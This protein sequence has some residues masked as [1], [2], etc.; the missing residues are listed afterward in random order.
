MKHY[1]ASIDDVFKE[2]QS[3]REGLTSEQAES[4][5]LK[6]GKN[7]LAEPEKDSIIKQFF[8][9]M[10]DPMIIMLLAAAVI[11]AGVSF[12]SG[13]GEI[14]DVI[15]I[16]FVVVVNA[17]LG[18]Y[19]ENKAEK[20]IEALAEIAAATTTVLR[21]GKPVTIKNEDLVVGD[22]VLLESG[23]AIPADGRIIGNTSMKIEEAV[24][25]WIRQCLKKRNRV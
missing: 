10:A 25:T 22:V 11:S 3:S 1:C 13:D 24:E 14:A 7:K 12:Y 20:A 23:D 16:L 9:Q 17:V 5:L 15:I 21:D 8:K 6:N 2:V 19:Q 4:R 18:V